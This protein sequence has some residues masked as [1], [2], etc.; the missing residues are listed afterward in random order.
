MTIT[1][2]RPTAKPPAA[3]LPHQARPRRPASPHRSAL[4]T[5]ESQRHVRTPGISRTKAGSA[6]ASLPQGIPAP[7]HRNDWFI[8]TKRRFKSTTRASLLRP[9]QA[10]LPSAGL[11][12][13]RKS[14]T[15]GKCRRAPWGKWAKRWLGPANRMRPETRL[16]TALRHQ[17]ELRHSISH[18]LSAN[19]QQSGRGRCVPPRLL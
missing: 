11:C 17:S 8:S 3:T 4:S 12:Q 1:G 6:A 14:G 2:R 7:E 10:S 15:D 13:E 18:R 16:F 9:S 19:R 5:P